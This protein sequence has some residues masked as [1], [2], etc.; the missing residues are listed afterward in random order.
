MRRTEFLIPCLLGGCLAV[1]ETDAASLRFFGTG[2]DAI[3][4]VVIAL[5]DPP[6]PVDVGGSFTLEF[7]MRAVLA[8]NPATVPCSA[9][10]DAW[11]EGHT[12]IDRDVYGPG[13]FGDYGVSLMQ[14]RLAFGV[15]VGSTGA[16]A[17]SSQIAADG[18]WRHVALSRDSDSGL[19]RIHIDGQL[20]VATPG[21][22]GNLAYRSGRPTPWAWDPFLVL[23]AEKHD[24]GP[25]YPSYAGW[26]GELRLS[27]GLRY[28]ASYIPPQA[29]L[30]AD[31]ATLALYRF[32]E[33][34]GSVLGDSAAGH[35]SPG[36]LRIGGPQQ[37][38]TWSVDS[39]YARVFADGFE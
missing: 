3:D 39:P 1:A 17:C 7:W 24:A 37:G 12:L 4:R 14:G 2:S 31:A 28:G 19:L 15:S 23:G 8:D 9:G 20:D 35:A 33:G 21:P 38:P 26:L 25:A 22:T 11:I 13:D 10:V 5:G 27:A 34:Q 18:R 32:D 29:P 16:T 30:P 6:R 36:E